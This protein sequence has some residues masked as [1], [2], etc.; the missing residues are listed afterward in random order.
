M[1][2]TC[3]PSAGRSATPSVTIEVSARRKI[4]NDIERLVSTS[5][6]TFVMGVGGIVFDERKLA[7]RA[8]MK[9]ILTLV[10]LQHECDIVVASIGGFDLEYSGERFGKEGYRYVTLLQRTGAD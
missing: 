5:G 4:G 7:G 3:L 6:D 8:Q 9:E 1:S 2:M 10:Q